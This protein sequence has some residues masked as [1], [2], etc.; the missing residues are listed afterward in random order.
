[1]KRLFS[2]FVLFGLFSPLV[3]IQSGACGDGLT[4]KNEVLTRWGYLYF[5]NWLAATFTASAFIL[6]GP[7][8]CYTGVHTQ[9]EIF[10]PKLFYE[11]VFV[12]CLMVLLHL[13]ALFLNLP[14]ISGKCGCTWS[15]FKVSRGG[16]HTALVN[17][18]SLLQRLQKYACKTVFKWIKCVVMWNC[19]RNGSG[20]IKLYNEMKYSALL[21]NVRLHLSSTWV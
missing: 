18:W 7:E 10:A 8:A 4:S 1:M 6:I 21:N 3:S 9:A 11:D 5:K 17:D 12:L 2:Y 14:H 15:K 20:M 13:P 16:C 19:T